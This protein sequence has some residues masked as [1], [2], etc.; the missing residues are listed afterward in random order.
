MTDLG[1]IRAD[2]SRRLLLL[3]P[4]MA[5]LATACTA[6]AEP[7]V[8]FGTGVRFVP[9]VVDAQD[10]VGLGA[11]VAL[12]ADGLP[13]VSYLG[14]PGELKPGEIA[15]SRPIGA[16]FLPGVMLATSSSDGI[17]TRGA[18]QQAKPALE[19]T[20]IGVPFG[21]DTVE[22]LTLDQ[23]GSNGTAIAVAEDGTVHV[24][25]TGNTG[26]FY[27]KTKA[28]G[29]TSAEQVFDYGFTLR[30][31]GPV[32]RPGIALDDG[33]NPWVAFSANGPRGIETSVARPGADGWDVETV[34]TADRC[35]GCPQP[36]PTGIASVGG[37]I[38]VVAADAEAGS[39]RAFTATSDGWSESTIESGVAASGLSLASGGDV[40][41]AAYYSGSGAVH[42]AALSAG[43]WTVSE[44]SSAAD[45]KVTTGN[46]APTTGVAVDD[47]G[48]VYVAWEDGGVHLVSGDGAAFAAIETIGTAGGISPSVAAGADGSVALAWYDPLSRNLMVGSV[49]AF[50]DLILANPSPH[51]TIDAGPAQ[52]TGCGDD[53][54]I[55]LDIV[56][57]GIAFDTNCLVAPAGEAFQIN[58]DNQD[59]AI[60]HNVSVYTEQ[61][62]D[63]IFQDAPFPGVKAVTY[64]VDPLDAGS[65]FF[66]CDVHPNMTG[67]LA[68]VEGAA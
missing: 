68:A 22:G 66:I 39:V 51:P 42:L 65:Y 15:A 41:Y 54:A 62:G 17:W 25:W 46:L 28:G 34:A 5:I 10:D 60:P 38:V 2:V 32:G 40:A 14:F 58:F 6:A 24:A 9:A 21:P 45:P 19:P 13:F 27:A 43:A 18:V 20:G 7:I 49:G 59:D 55:L 50:E 33:G 16:A 12:S 67:T 48:T 52:P 63:T 29:S 30:K 31:A 56:A 64:D 36:G 1:S 47:A 44:V 4:I 26:V 8:D 35:N 37:E 11:S 23:D 57:L 61:G 3:A 53:G